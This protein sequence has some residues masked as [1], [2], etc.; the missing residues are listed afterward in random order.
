MF[1]RNRETEGEVSADF[2]CQRQWPPLPLIAILGS[3]LDR[4][5]Q[6]ELLNFII[7]SLLCYTV[8]CRFSSHADLHSLKEI[9]LDSSTLPKFIVPLCHLCSTV[10]CR[11]SSH[12]DLH[13]TEELK[14]L[15]S[16]VLGLKSVSCR[17]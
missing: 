3:Y 8:T 7:G 15:G 9:M 4:Q 14:I 12:A 10:T 1:S 2:T 6:P 5:V 16:H 17:H 11:F 13:I